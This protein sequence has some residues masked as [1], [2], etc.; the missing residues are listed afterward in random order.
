MSTAPARLPYL[1]PSALIHVSANLSPVKHCHCDLEAD[2]TDSLTQWSST[3]T[4]SI[5]D[6]STL[7]CA[8]VLVDSRLSN[9]VDIPLS[10]LFTP[11][12]T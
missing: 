11:A 1:S 5:A 2:S 10:I 7:I 8:P 4:V 3:L 9:L 12:G 6:R